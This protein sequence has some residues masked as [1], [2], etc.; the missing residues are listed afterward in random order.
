MTFTST[1]RNTMPI[2]VEPAVMSIYVTADTQE[3]LIPIPWKDCKLVHA[4]ACFDVAEGTN[5]GTIDIELNT[6]GG[7]DM[8]SIAV[9]ADQ[10]AGTQ[11]EGTVQTASNN[12]NLDREEA[13]R[14]NVNLEVAGSAADYT[15][16]VYLYF[17][18]QTTVA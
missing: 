18:A 6:A 12:I 2:P 11:V 16:M 8:Y 1:M 14:D 5:T 3:L 4:V 7:G 9:A 13:T 10:G 17:E 15:C